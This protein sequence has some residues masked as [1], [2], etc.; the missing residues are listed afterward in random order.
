[1]PVA[2]FFAPPSGGVEVTALER[3]IGRVIDV[4][5]GSGRFGLAIQAR[6]QTVLGLDILAD[7]VAVMRAR[8]LDARQGRVEDCAGAGADTLLVMMNGT[9][10]AGSLTG[11]APLL[12]SLRTGMAADGRILIDSTD[13]DH[14]NVEWDPPG[15]GRAAGELHL[16]M[17]FRGDWGAP[18]PQLFVGPEALANEARRV[19]LGLAVVAE[20]PDGRFLAELTQAGD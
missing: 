20:D 1:M 7:A 8:G 4:G 3:A 11:L 10:L 14:P 18:H 16:Q 17:G 13:P 15:D 9:T 6:G 12:H 5:A 2:T 19:G